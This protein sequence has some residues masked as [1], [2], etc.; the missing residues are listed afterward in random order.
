MAATRCWRRRGPGESCG[1]CRPPVSD[2]I[3]GSTSWRASR[4]SSTC[5]LIAWTRSR[6]W[7]AAL[8]VRGDTWPWD[9]DLTQRVCVVVGAEG[10]GVHRL[11]LERCDVRLRLP[12]KGRIGSFNASAAA[13]A[14]LYEVTRQ[15][16]LH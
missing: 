13:A 8:D 9:F 5:R 1:S 16:S 6:I 11:V 15:R 2:T 7:C 3:L 12:V 14:L 10:Q 4:R